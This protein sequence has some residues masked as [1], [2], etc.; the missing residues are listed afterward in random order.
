MFIGTRQLFFLD[1]RVV[2]FLALL[3]S[4]FNTVSLV[5]TLSISRFDCFG[6]E[7]FAFLLPVLL[8]GILVTSCAESTENPHKS[9]DNPHAGSHHGE[10]AEGNKFSVDGVTY[11]KEV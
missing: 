3:V 5:L 10:D 9:G 11:E 1:L 4:D 8:C 6:S 7:G 2:A